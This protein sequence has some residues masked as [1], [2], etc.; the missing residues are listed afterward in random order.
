MSEPRT[1]THRRRDHTRRALIVATQELLAEQ[2]PTVS[3]QAITDRADVGVGSLYNHFGD[4][5]TLFAA[6]GAAAFEDFEAWMVAGTGGLADP[7]E[8]FATR[9]RL[10]AG[11]PATH[12]V[13]A[14]LAVE[15]AATRTRGLVNADYALRDVLDVLDSRGLAHTNPEA[16]LV[17][18]SGAAMSLLVAA[19]ASGR[20]DVEQNAAVAEAAMLALGLDPA[21]AADVAHRP[22][23]S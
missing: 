15:P 17:L 21:D 7:A 11:C 2:G 10:I 19:S 23:P 5:E 13:T 14:R 6:A 22:L 4:K 20:T 16:L 1:R 3:V 12:P 9:V 18:A 8:R